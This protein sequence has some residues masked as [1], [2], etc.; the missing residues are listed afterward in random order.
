MGPL[1][2]YPRTGARCVSSAMSLIFVIPDANRSRQRDKHDPAIEQ[3]RGVALPQH[4]ARASTEPGLVGGLAERAGADVAH[5]ADSLLGDLQ[6]MAHSPFSAA[7][8][9]PGAGE[10]VVTANLPE[11]EAE[12]NRPLVLLYANQWQIYEERPDGLTSWH[13]SREFSAIVCKAG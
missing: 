4:G 2:A 8:S 3:Q 10:R 6:G 11:P 13:C 5:W 1:G 7:K 9:A 12:A